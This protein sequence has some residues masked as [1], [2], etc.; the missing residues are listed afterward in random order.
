MSRRKFLQVDHIRYGHSE[1]TDK[2]IEGLMRYFQ[3]DAYGK[4]V[5]LLNFMKIKRY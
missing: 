4:L 2:Q 1:Y 5:S 3:I